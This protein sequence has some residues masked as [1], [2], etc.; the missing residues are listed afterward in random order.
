MSV[1][2]TERLQLGRGFMRAAVVLAYLIVFA[3]VFMIVVT[4]FF[5]QQIVSF[6]PTGL[7][8]HWYVNAWENPEFLRGLVTSL[9][10]ALLASAVGVPIGTAAAHALVR[11]ESLGRTAIS[12]VLLAPLGP[13]GRGRGRPLHV[14]RA[15]RRRS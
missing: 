11:G 7:T 2:L 15:G 10:V 9:Q 1:R 3:P 13:W 12:T 8:W 4:S 5:S 6:P 14:L